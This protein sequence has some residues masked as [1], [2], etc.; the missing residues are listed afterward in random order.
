MPVFFYSTDDS[1]GVQAAEALRGLRPNHATTIRGLD[2]WRFDGFDLVQIDSRTVRF[3]EADAFGTDLVVFLSKHAGA[4]GRPCFTCHVTG[5]F[6]PA[7]A[8][9]G[10]LDQVLS[11]ASAFWLKRFYL[12]LKERTGNVSL[13]A[14]H[15]G[16]ALETPSVFVETGSEEN[17]WKKPENGQA[18]AESVLSGLARSDGG[19]VALGFGGTHYC[20]AFS[21]LLEEGWAFSHVASKHSVGNVTKNLVQQAVEKTVEPVQTVFLDWK[22]LPAEKRKAIPVLCEELGLAWERL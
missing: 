10:G 7:N 21:P 17:E 14:T 5:S 8:E 4:S 19:K 2:A 9:M 18:L 11:R 20:S 12:A 16:P 15:H 13:E 1:A 3:Q 6:G 22:G